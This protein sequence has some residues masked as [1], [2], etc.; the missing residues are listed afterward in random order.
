MKPLPIGIQTFADLIEGGFLYVDKTAYI[1]D[2][3]STAKGVYFLSRPRRFGKSLLLTTLKALFLG[4]RHL[5][6]G[7]AIDSLDYDWAERP[8]IHIDMSLKRATTPDEFRTF[9]SNRVDDIAGEYGV[10]L[11]RPAY[12]DRFAELIRRL[13]AKG[14]VVVLVDEYD[15]PILDNILDVEKAAEMREV[16]K[17][18][19]TVIKACDEYLRFVFLTG[20]S[21]F[22]RVSVFSGLNNLA[23]ITMNDR[24]A[25]ML[26][27]TEAEL[28]SEFAEQIGELATACDIDR[29]GTLERIREWYNGYQFSPNGARVYNP[30]S[31]LLLFRGLRFAPYWFETGT[32]TFLVEMIRERGYD[33]PGLDELVVTED[34][35]STFEIERL[36]IEPL[37]FQ[38][39]YLTIRGYE[40]GGVFTLGYPNLEVRQ[41]FTA[42]LLKF[43]SG[44]SGALSG[45]RLLALIKALREVDMPQFFESMRCF[46]AD[47]PYDIQVKREQYYQT[48]FYLIFSLMGIRIQAEVR[49]NRGRVDAVAETDND[50]F[51]FEFKLDGSAEDAL[52]QI[53]EKG[54]IE[55]YADTTKT[56]HLIGVAFDHAERNIGDWVAEPAERN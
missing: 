29:S 38:T 25:D 2:L 32:P 55:K 18:F 36:E 48:I 46:F 1:A 20:V 54:Y 16:L 5:F 37:L 22:S 17:G 19:Y 15:K 28:E 12:D 53:R 11:E 45:S 34:V 24:Y 8:V 7:L 26:G 21:K 44:L 40:E 14:K 9:L 4:K 49:T 56:V 31:T 42:N 39:G 47:I 43:H 51:I 30:F 13:S 3:V 41:A 27:Y 6:K 10:K 35:F 33:V 50:V 23:D 52:A